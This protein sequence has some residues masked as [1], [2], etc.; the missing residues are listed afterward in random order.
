MVDRLLYS[1]L[2]IGQS[3]A[4]DYLPPS[5]DDI[6]VA[7]TE[8]PQGFQSD[9][10][11]VWDWIRIMIVYDESVNKLSESNRKMT[12]HVI[13]AARDY[14]QSTVKVQ[15]LSSLQLPP[16]CLEP[17]TSLT[18][19]GTVVCIN[20]CAKKCAFATAPESADYFSEECTCLV[21][22]SATFPAKL[23]EGKCASWSEQTR[24]GKLHNVDFVVFVSALAEMC[25]NQQLAAFA[26]HCAIDPSTKR[27]IAGQVNI[28]PH[29]FNTT[30]FNEL[31]KLE[32][33]VKHELTHAFVFSPTLLQDFP[34]AGKYKR[35]DNSYVIDNVVDRFTRLDWETSNGTMKHDVFMMVTPKVREEARRHFNC[36]TLEGAELENHG[37]FGIAGVH[38]EK[39]IYEDETMS[40][41]LT[42][43]A[44]NGAFS[45]LTL[46]LFEDSGWYKVNYDKAEEMM[47]GRNLGCDFAKR[48]CLSWM[49]KNMEDPYPFCNTYGD[50]KTSTDMHNTICTDSRNMKYYNYSSE[51]ICK[52]KRLLIKT[53][54]S[55]TFSCKEGQFIHI[56][57]PPSKDDVKVGITE[58]LQSYQTSSEPVWDWIRIKI[59]YDDS[60]NELS[61][62]NRK[63][64][65]YLVSAARDFFQST[66]KVQRLS[67]LQLPT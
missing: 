63:M 46:A 12:E 13:T 53:Q 29:T 50:V 19:N 30:A 8:Y 39:R 16:S 14:F 36:S 38:W 47:W 24:G 20:D 31:S 52:E 51:A 26:I 21:Y 11:T 32:E 41:G 6:M 59:E 1:V 35:K 2:L 3:L 27:P 60:V 5:K 15:R 67:S 44:Q 48:S 23:E 4:C 7:I 58:Y 34:G 65:Y 40:A 25:K 54:N 45:R 57:Q 43:T 10:E 17:G 42:R 9:S 18:H 55:T 56:E 64:V 33:A 22:T 61:E 49:K 62:S 28:C 66:I 37:P